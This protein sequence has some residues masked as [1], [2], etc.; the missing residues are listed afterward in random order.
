MK[1]GSKGTLNFWQKKTP[2]KARSSHRNAVNKA[3][4]IRILHLSVKIFFKI[5]W[6][7]EKSSYLCN[8]KS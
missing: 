5:V 3:F 7:I 8:P 1:L 4:K 2:G 6:W